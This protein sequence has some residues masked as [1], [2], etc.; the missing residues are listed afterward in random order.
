MAKGICYECPDREVGCHSKCERFLEYKQ[1]NADAEAA[2]QKAWL[3]ENE[4]Y[5]F[6]KDNVA[7][8]KRRRGIK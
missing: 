8:Y 1:K 5:N 7:R 2:K 3:S 6:K 4:F